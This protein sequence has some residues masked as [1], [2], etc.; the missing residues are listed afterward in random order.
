[1]LLDFDLCTNEVLLFDNE[2]CI[3]YDK[4]K[5]RDNVK[6]SMSVNVGRPDMGPFVEGKE[7][8]GNSLRAKIAARGGLLSPAHALCASSKQ[9]PSRYG[10]FDETKST[11]SATRSLRI[12]NGKPLKP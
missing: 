3:F 4:A 10:D 12:A 5:L 11:R 7:T 9:S 6:I 1:M 8:Y 2:S